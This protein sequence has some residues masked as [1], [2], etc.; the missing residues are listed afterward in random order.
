MFGGKGN[1]MQKA[2]PQFDNGAT[3]ITRN[4]DHSTGQTNVRPVT[5]D[6]NSPMAGKDV[7]VVNNM[8]GT[9]DEQSKDQGFFGW[10]GSNLPFVGDSSGMTMASVNGDINLGK[11]PAPAPAP[12]LSPAPAPA[13]MDPAAP[14][15]PPPV[16][17]PAPIES[18]EPDADM[19]AKFR[20]GTAST[21]DP[22]SKMDKFKMQQ[23]MHGNKNWASNSA[24][25]A[26]RK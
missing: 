15:P 16:A 24:Y 25:R 17:A 4:Y 3:S 20:K 12:A 13:T 19:L 22:N 2:K 18:G 26:S 21:F 6:K 11:K 1:V 8:Y 23:L 14:V 10:T 9:G 5:V 7:S